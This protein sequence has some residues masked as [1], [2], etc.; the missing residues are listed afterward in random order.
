MPDATTSR[1]A[2]TFPF[3][4]S[5]SEL[6]T[7]SSSF[8]T[9]AYSRGVYLLRSVNAVTDASVGSSPPGFT[10]ADRASC[11]TFHEAGA[12]NVNPGPDDTLALRS[13]LTLFRRRPRRRSRRPAR[14]WRRE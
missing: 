14:A 7:A 5:A 4:L 11:E 8:E 3:S 6:V 12:E 13:V 9:F 2:I 10:V 1:R